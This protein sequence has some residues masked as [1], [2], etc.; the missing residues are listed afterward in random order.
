MYR[1]VKSTK[2]S[3]K[4]TVGRHTYLIDVQSKDT[5]KPEFTVKQEDGNVEAYMNASRSRRAVIVKN[6][7]LYKA[8][9]FAPY[10]EE[11][12]LRSIDEWFD[13][14]IDEVIAELEAIS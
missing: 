6:D 3:Y 2:T 8:I 14:M 10:D 11:N 13:H 12:S 7:N 4:K 9:N 1:Y 5:N